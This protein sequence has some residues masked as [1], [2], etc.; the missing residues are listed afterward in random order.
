M[1]MKIITQ[2]ILGQPILQIIIIIIIIIINQPLFLLFLL[3]HFHSSAIILFF[4]K[5]LSTISSLISESS[6]HIYQ[7]E[8]AIT[9]VRQ[10]YSQTGW[11]KA[12]KHKSGV[13]VHMLQKQSSNEKLAVFK[14]ETT[15]HGFSP[16]SIFHVIGMRRLWDDMFE[17]GSLVENLNET[18]SIT[19]EAY[20]SSGNSRPYDLTLVEKI[21][22]SND[23]MIVFACTSVET[24]KMPKVSGRVRN[25]VKLQGWILK[26]LPTSPPSTH[27]TFITEE[28]VRGW[29]PGLTKKS[30]AR[31][32]LILASIDEY[33]QQKARTT[34]KQHDVSSSSIPSYQQQRSNSLNPLSAFSQQKR[35]SIMSPSV[36]TLSSSSSILVNPPPRHSSLSVTRSPSGVSTQ[37]STK[38]IT[39]ADDVHLPPP[40][41]NT[42]EVLIPIT[43]SQEEVNNVN[44]NNNEKN[45][46]LQQEDESP[47]HSIELPSKLYPP[48]RHKH[49]RKEA[50]AN[51]KRLLA[52]DLDEWR[53]IGHQ[54]GVDFYS[55]ASQG[56]T[57][58]ILR[59]D[60]FIKGNWSPEQICSVV[61]CFGARKKWDTHF[62]KGKI[63]ERFSQ[64][65]Y[66]VYLQM[67]SIF[68]I[69]SRDFAVL[70]HIESDSISGTIHV[71]SSTVSDS[72]IPETEE[73]I[74]G[75][76]LL[77]GWTFQT[78]KNNQGQR[79]GVNMTFISHMDLSGTIPLPSSIIRLLTSEVPSSVLRVQQFMVSVGCPPYI[80]RVAGK[81]MDEDYDLE[82]CQYT[83]SYIAKHSPSKQHQ[84]NEQNW[85]TDIRIHAS[86]YKYGFNITTSPSLGV[87]TVVRPD[88]AGVRIYTENE[89]LNGTV[90]LVKI[91]A[92]P[93]PPPPSP[94]PTSTV[95][96]EIQSIQE[97][98]DKE[99]ND[100]VDMDY[101]TNDNDG[102]IVEEKEEKE[103]EKEE[104]IKLESSKTVRFSVVHPLSNEKI[105]TK[106]IDTT[107]ID[108][109]IDQDSHNDI[110]SIHPP[111]K[112]ATSLETPMMRPRSNSIIV[113]GE[114]L[115]FNGQQISL[116][117]FLMAI[118]YYVGKLS[119]RCY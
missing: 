60:G 52:T 96:E 84:Q 95:T 80:R 112:P 86:I 2:T 62:E 42:S 46:Q 98:N 83:M 34:L 40:S 41:T 107:H 22:C 4:V 114:N 101:N 67:Q 110:P 13:V 49:I 31:K 47:K 108:K 69:Q 70:T 99:N 44:E 9:S 8:K 85:C 77:Y 29:I 91:L 97:N 10:L 27:V 92:K 64:K 106:K 3:I 6:Y 78:I 50:L 61:Q 102:K 104:K 75:K 20:R 51:Y 58:P 16:Q 35:P 48:A 19:Y 38:R 24:N 1:M 43:E 53:N 7:A 73:H 111:F 25:N 94:S 117:F 15:I 76:L 65:E 54:E 103:K 21:D 55:K 72:L 12:L 63:V 56:Y 87:R 17:D 30:L 74:R 90:I 109:L 36:K 88:N 82:T 37:H 100:Q 14:G 32:P 26:A 59:G 93:P 71:I 81:V 45:N 79:L 5:Y 118:S 115:S 66:L 39:F 23:G 33:L 18:T 68:P 89:S 116:I 119:C 105:I 28:V 113:I 57:L 11:K